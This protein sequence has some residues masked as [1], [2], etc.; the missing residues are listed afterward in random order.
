MTVTDMT[1]NPAL[2]RSPGQHPAFPADLSTWVGRPHLLATV[3]ASAARASGNSWLDL[4]RT[5]VPATPPDDL[6]VVV[7][8]C[9]LQSVFHSIDVVRRLDEDDDL[10]E[11][12]SQLVVRT[13]QIRRFRR[14][15]RRVL[16]DCLTHSL[17]SLWKQR[18]PTEGA[19]LL[20]GQLLHNRAEFR[21]L[22]PFYLHA[23]DRIDRAVVLDSMALDY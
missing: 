20:P 19:G 7:A 10:V 17:V 5:E 23:Q 9:Y 4:V 22:E 1:E 2:T 12:R 3:R 16:S 18:H 13:E 14:D 11:L 21:F 8:Y 15:H 6:L